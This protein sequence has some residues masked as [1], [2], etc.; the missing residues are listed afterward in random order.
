MA[1]EQGERDH[2]VGDG[3][4][5]QPRRMRASLTASSAAK[6]AA[7]AADAAVAERH[8]TGRR[9][10]P[11]RVL[12]ADEQPVALEGATQFLE[13][14]GSFEVVARVHD[15]AQLAAANKD[16]MPDVVILDLAASGRVEGTTA[17]DELLAAD[18]AARVLVL[19]ADT[20]PV[21]VGAALE[22][23][24]AGFLP[25]TST[26]DQLAAAVRAVAAGEHYVHPRLAAAVLR[27]LRQ[28]EGS[29]IES[30][31]TDREL[32]VLRLVADG[33]TNTRIAGALDVADSTVKTHVARILQKLDA[34]DRAHAVALAFRRGLID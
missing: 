26:A 30:G 14:A 28:R 32:A 13:R 18:A 11:I 10:G 4:T 6:A 33:M 9:S 29:R 34:T 31:L 19:S 24:C 20:S 25:K 7:A 17:L 8:P 23:G 1:T 12:V 27:I 21:A 2:G 3:D 5:R 22:R 15:L 16:A